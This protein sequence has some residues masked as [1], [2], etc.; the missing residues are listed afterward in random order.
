MITKEQYFW[1]VCIY[2]SK[3]KS[4]NRNGFCKII[5][6]SN[7]N[8]KS[9]NQ[10]INILKENNIISFGDDTS[11]QIVIYINRNKLEKFIRKSDYFKL[12]DEFIHKS[13]LFAE[14]GV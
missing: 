13:T 7:T 6:I 4:Y 12:T 2:N 9:Y 3:L 5:N 10:I 1:L 8:S 14:T 11:N